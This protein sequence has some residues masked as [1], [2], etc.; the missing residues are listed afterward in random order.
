M[1]AF[2]GQDNCSV[3]ANGRIKFSPRV[4]RDFME[5]C[6]GEVVLHCL[7]EGALAVYPEEVYLQMRSAE[8]RPAERASSSMVFRRNLRRF[9]A[10]SQSEKISAQ[11]RI[12][13]TSAFREFA[14]LLPGTDAVVVGVEIGVEVWNAQ[15]WQQELEKL[16]SHS[17]EKGQREMEADLAAAEQ[18]AGRGDL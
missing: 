14:D 13:L 11:G 5:R 4:I 1:L 10:L 12:T 3:D 16:N 9:G 18:G 8:P 6:S 2:C 17:L 7:P 15:R